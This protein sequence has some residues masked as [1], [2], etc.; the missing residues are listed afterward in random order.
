MN[1]KVR[2]NNIEFRNNCNTNPSIDKGE[3]LV[4][5]PCS[6]YGKYDEYIK[7]GCV[8]KNGFVRDE[9]NRVNISKEFFDIKETCYV[10]AWLNYD[11]KEWCCDLE[12][13]GPR[14]LELNDENRKDFFEVYKIADKKMNEVNNTKED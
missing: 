10:I 5:Q 3:F 11:K 1:I 7:N 4:W 8:E 6:Y 2:I 13:V 9:R 14:L 12:S